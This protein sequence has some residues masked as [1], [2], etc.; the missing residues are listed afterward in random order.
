VILGG[1]IAK[2]T[3][4]R[5]AFFATSILSA[6]I[7]LIGLYMLEETYPPLL[8]RRRKRTIIK[9]TGDT[10]YYTHYDYLDHV[11]VRV[12]SQNLVRPLKLLAI[13]PIVL[14][15]GFVQCL[16]VR[17][18]LD[19]LRG[20]RQPLHGSLLSKCPDCWAQLCLHC[21]Q[22]RPGH[23]DIQHDHRSHIPSLVEPER[24]VRE[25]KILDSRRGT[26]HPSPRHRHVLVWLVS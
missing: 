16:S 10:R 5:W 1:F 13:Q 17:Q 18:Y 20:L 12:L 8:L 9:E 2:Y 21:H 15:H 11:T 23:S 7:Q 3:T 22:S 25:T 4:W 26:G 6:C 24:W 14:S 19:L